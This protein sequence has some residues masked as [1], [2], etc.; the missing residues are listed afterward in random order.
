MAASGHTKKAVNLSLLAFLFLC[1]LIVYLVSQGGP[2]QQIDVPGGGS[3]KFGPRTLV[4]PEKAEE[5]STPELRARQA[6]LE[7]K[8]RR[9]DEQLAAREK[10][11][12]T[13]G[14]GPGAGGVTQAPAEMNLAGPW[15]GAQGLYSF[16]LT[17]SGPAL[18]LQWFEPMRGLIAVGQ[19][20][21]QGRTLNLNYTTIFGTQGVAQLQAS[22]D[23]LQ[24]TGGFQ[25]L[26]T[27]YQGPLFL[28]R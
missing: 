21:L 14:S 3:V 23:G 18:A 10:S 7:E 20:Q 8:I 12:G 11:A 4:G 9:L 27:G 6:E 17:Q 1:G 16:T 15:Q 19:G 26:T 25:D 22:P 2:V 13:G 24:L 28:T 5:T